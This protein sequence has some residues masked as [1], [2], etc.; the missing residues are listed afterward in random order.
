[1][2][3]ESDQLVF[4]YLSRVGDLAQQRQLP[5]NTRMRLVS[6]LRGEIDR[7]RATRG[8]E[9]PAAVRGILRQLGTPDELVDRA[10]GV[11]PVPGLPEPGLPEQRGRRWR[12]G[13]VPTPRPGATATSSK[14]PSSSGAP[15]PHLAG[16][17]EVGAADTEPDWWRM[18]ATP[19]PGDDLV[20]GFVGG[21]EIPELLKPPV[22]ADAD[23]DQAGDG[24]GRAG[25]PEAGAP[26]RPWA[27]RLPWARRDAVGDAGAEPG[28]DAAPGPAVVPRSPRLA[29]PFLLLAALLL[30]GGALFGSL[31]ALAFGWLLAWA[32]RRLTRRE[33]QVAVIV[34]PG[35]AATAGAVWLWGRVAGRWGQPIVEGGA[36]MGAALGDTW[37]WVVRVAAVSSALFLLWRSQRR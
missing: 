23:A 12:R 36:A 22:D 26:G 5:S 17:D 8:E 10:A 4:D 28:A 6:G 7:R 21:V 31:P 34:L 24:D 1:M 32:S 19:R 30:L 3:I 9:S 13:G 33:V 37:P 29:N 27:R 16:T 18:E 15:S 2:G 20:P 25:G 11:D 35:L 14:R